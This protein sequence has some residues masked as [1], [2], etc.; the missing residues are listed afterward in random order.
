MLKMETNDKI[1]LNMA[2]NNTERG[3]Y[4]NDEMFRLL[5][6]ARYRLYKKIHNEVEQDGDKL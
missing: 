4:G 1:L 5:V 2:I 3:T 6:K